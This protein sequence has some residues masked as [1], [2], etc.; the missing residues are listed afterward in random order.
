MGLLSITLVGS[1]NAYG[2]E[3]DDQGRDIAAPAPAG[4]VAPAAPSTTPA[5]GT[6]T[7]GDM[8]VTGQ[9]TGGTNPPPAYAGGQV[10]SGGRIG[11]LGEQD[12]FNTPFSVISYTSQIIDNQQDDTV[13]SV[14]EN[15]AG[16]QKAYGSGTAGEIFQIRGFPLYGQD[17]SFGGL[18]GVLPRQIVQTNFVNRVELFKGANAFANGVSP[19]GSGVGGAV[20]LEPK[21]A[22]DDPISRLKLGYASDSQFEQEVDVGRRFGK[23]QRF[24]VRLDAQHEK[25]DTALNDENAADTSVGLGLDYRG[26]R[27]RAS[28]YFGY[29]R[30]HLKHFRSV[31][32]TSNATEVPEPPDADTNYA[33]S[34]AQTELKTEFGLLR[35]SF[36]FTDHWTGYAAIGANHSREDSDYAG[37]LLQD[38][39]GNAGAYRISVPYEA[40]LFT[41]QAGFRGNFDTGPI[42]HKINVGYSGYYRRMNTAYRQSSLAALQSTN[43]YDPAA[44]PSPPT[45]VSGGDFDNPPIRNR[46]RADGWAISDTAGLFND[47]LLLTVGARYQSLRIEN[48]SAEGVFNEPAI[49]NHAVSPAYGV[50]VKPLD[51]LSLYANHIEALQA[52]DSAPTQSANFGQVVGIAESK[53]NEVGGKVDFG[54]IGGSLA[55]YEIEQPSAYTDPVTNIYGYYGKQRNRGL[56]VSVFGKPTKRLRLM[57]SA[58]WIDPELSDTANGANDGNNAVGV[59]D[60]RFVFQG[61][62]QL[63]SLPNWSANARVIRSGTQYADAANTLKL[64]PWTRIDL[65]LRYKMPWGDNERHITW[66]ANVTNVANSDYWASAQSGYLTQGDPRTFKL[67]ATVDF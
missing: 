52:G 53:Q 62:W 7:L 57:A 65:G 31:I 30:Q 42:S 29:Q 5:A 13:G 34:Y 37:L 64:A 47:K 26:E 58:S 21:W 28:A 46:H 40:N 24:G 33:P 14:L 67:S 25:G 60:Y 10:A 22:T 50:V 56:E 45:V 48:Y 9:L 27:A 12:A 11:V 39:Q 4:D 6:T 35:G 41:G 2:A 8:L 55:L 49:V 17:I 66:R 23:N 43:I 54:T 61:D 19:G 63:P 3:P 20:N 44:L 59:A 16:V 18:Y 51:W 15:D 36:D 32:Y 1:L 38:D